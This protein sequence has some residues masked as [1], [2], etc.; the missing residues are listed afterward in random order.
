MYYNFCNPA[1]YVFYSNSSKKFIFTEYTINATELTV[2]MENKY[3][4]R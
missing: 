3:V 2:N 1:L 4:T